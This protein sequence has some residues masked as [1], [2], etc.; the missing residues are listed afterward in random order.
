[1][2]KLQIEENYLLFNI[3]LNRPDE[4]LIYD[5][6]DTKFSN[7]LYLYKNIKKIFRVANGSVINLK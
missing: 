1:M 6:I 2:C 4:V 7:E 3:N 5:W